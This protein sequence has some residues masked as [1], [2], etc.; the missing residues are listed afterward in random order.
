MCTCLSKMNVNSEFQKSIPP[1]QKSIGKCKTGTKKKSWTPILSWGAL[2]VGL[3]LVQ[4]KAC[5]TRHWIPV[6]AICLPAPLWAPPR[7]AQAM[8]TQC[9]AAESGE[10]SFRSPRSTRL[11][12]T[13]YIPL[14][15]GEMASG[16]RQNS[17]QFKDS[18]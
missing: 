12:E 11:T 16:R 8:G 1:S 5:L 17:C 10:H 9:S 14:G 15:E 13:V 18:K 7:T 6:F 3:N 4:V 2:S